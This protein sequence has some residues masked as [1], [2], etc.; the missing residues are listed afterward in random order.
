MNPGLYIHIPFCRRKCAYCG[1][2]SRAGLTA[3]MQAAYAKALLRE[4]SFVSRSEYGGAVVKPETLYIGGGTPSLL[5]VDFYADLL[6]AL[7]EFFDFSDLREA[8]FEA[9]PEGLSEDYL[10]GLYQHTPIRRLSIGI[11]SFFDEDL[12]RL[13]RGHTGQ[14]AVQAV[15]NARKSGFENLSVDL[16]FGLYDKEPQSRWKE[17]L[18]RLAELSVPHF[19]AYALTVEPGTLLAKQ[20]EKG[21][22]RIADEVLLEKEYLYLQ[23]FARETG[24]EAYEIS[25]FA[26]AG[27]YAEH[28]TNYWRARPY[29]GL[30]ASAHSFFG[31]RR[32]WNASDLTAYVTDPVGSRQGET[33]SEKDLYHEYVMTAL[34]TVWGVEEENLRRFP[35]SL[36]VDFARQAGRQCRL[37]NLE[38]TPKGYRVPDSRRFLT[39]GIAVEFF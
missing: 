9:N 29:V 16:I 22:V 37:G 23:Q 21:M 1:F 27:K 19:S 8:T 15:E 38:P 3:E 20:L 28:N 7:S 25:N 6:K 39:D 10:R 36:Q 12:K 24:Y 30:G 33:L 14:E 18:A 5:P 11:Q 32:V 2:F 4:A 13:N 31:N 17:N 34:R 26:R 35:P